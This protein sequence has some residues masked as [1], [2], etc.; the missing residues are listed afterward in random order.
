MLPDKVLTFYTFL[1]IDGEGG[2]G[3]RRDREDVEMK[4]TQGDEP[5]IV[6]CGKKSQ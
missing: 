4:G 6:H 3:G 5:Q 1:R 2:G